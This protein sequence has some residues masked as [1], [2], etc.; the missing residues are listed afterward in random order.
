MPTTT[1]KGLSYAR[2]E[3]ETIPLPARLPPASYTRQAK[4]HPSLSQAF[5]SAQAAE[6]ECKVQR[7]IS[8]EQGDA[9]IERVPEGEWQRW[10]GRENCLFFPSGPRKTAWDIM[11][12]GLI[13]YSCV[14]VP[15]RIGMGKD[16]EGAQAARGRPRL[17]RPR[18]F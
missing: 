3:D 12:L 9:R 4:Q 16:A 8:R 11:M 17:A 18:K 6:R 14:S 7:R 1:H 5:A 10:A 15:F 13:L 2:L